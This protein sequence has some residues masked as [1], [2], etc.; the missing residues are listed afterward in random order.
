MSVGPA[1]TIVALL[2]L[3]L[4]STAVASDEPFHDPTI[5]VTVGSSAFVSARFDSV[6]L[7]LADGSLFVQGN[8]STDGGKT[9]TVSPG[10]VRS[11]FHDEWRQTAG[12]VLR[13]GT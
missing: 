7:K 13:D 5:K 9:W 11:S 2:A 1:R 12:C 4:P 10:A 3:T 6:L 8:R